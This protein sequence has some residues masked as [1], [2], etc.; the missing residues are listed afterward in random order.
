MLHIKLF[1]SNLDINVFATNYKPYIGL[2][3]LSL[4]IMIYVLEFYFNYVVNEE[5]SNESFSFF[6]NMENN[7]SFLLALVYLYK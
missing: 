2:I 5:T 4:L 6:C 7:I 1:I 3:Y